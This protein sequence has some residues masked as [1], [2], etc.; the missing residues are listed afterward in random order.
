M[1]DMLAE[2]PAFLAE[3]PA[4][5]APGHFIAWLASRRPV[6]V[7]L[8]KGRRLDVGNLE[9]LALAEEWL[10]DAERDA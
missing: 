7:H 3:N 6:Q 10:E 9:S 2:L 4:A 1:H 8:M 5:D